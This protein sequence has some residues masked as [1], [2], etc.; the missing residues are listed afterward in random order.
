M[1]SSIIRKTGL[2]LSAPPFN[3]KH[4]LNVNEM[5]TSYQYIIPLLL[6]GYFLFVSCNKGILEQ[7]PPDAVTTGTFWKSASD[8]DYALTGLYN[9]LYDNGG[10]YATSQFQVFAWDNFSDDSY[11]QYNY[12]GG[13]TATTAGILPATGD[14]TGSY[15]GSYYANCYSSIAADNSFLANVGKVLSGTALTQYRGEALF[16]RGF[17]YFWLAQLY[18]NVP[19]VTADPFTTDYSTKMAKSP[20][21]DV[22]KRASDDLDSA[23]AYL[24]D[25]A[26]TKG[27]VTKSTAE[28]YKVRLLLFEQKYAEAAALAQQI[29]SS[30]MYSLNT[31]YAANFYKPDQKTSP[32]IM[33][34]VQYQLP[35][36]QHQ[37]VAFAVS[38][39]YWKGELATQDLVDEYEPGDPRKTMTLFFP[40]DGA[41]QGWPFTNNNGV[42]TP[43][44][45]SWIVG[46][47][48]VKKWLTPGIANPNYGTLDDNDIVLL[49][50]ADIKLMYAEAQN[51]AAGPDASVYQQV[52]DVR[53]RP[54][55][56]M[57]GLPAGLTQDQMRQ[58]IRHERRVEFALEGLRYF[59]LRR[60]GIA[61]QKL[62][63]FHPNP[64]TPAVTYVY[65]D[66]YQFWPIPQTEID[67]NKPTLV[68]NDGY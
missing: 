9:F 6:A 16:L 28:G 56:S 14:L 45:D 55:V 19:I 24:P 39:Q 21:A 25:V 3:F 27:H 58:K 33:F 11:G 30:N 61:T 53:A 54:G 43:G 36:A 63:G 68:Q 38:L 62:N 7:N 49:R 1:V 8:A 4:I 64:V 13:L 10:G 44:S 23:I 51:E 50:Y 34:S 35:N 2:L 29:I 67:R 26:F 60:W 40:G 42:A 31:N 5:K 32:E 59:D 18:G 12:G 65:K 22:L 57:P 37:D 48:A 46:Y 15:V 47:Y 52:N 17:N 66:N 41:A 20:R